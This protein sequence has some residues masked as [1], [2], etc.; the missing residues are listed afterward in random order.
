MTLASIRSML[1]A[2][3]GGGGRGDSDEDDVSWSFA[4]IMSFDTDYS[5]VRMKTMMMKVECMVGVIREEIE[6]VIMML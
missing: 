4:R 3:F 6:K 2:R 5:V 1:Q